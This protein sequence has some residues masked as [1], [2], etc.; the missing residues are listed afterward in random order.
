MLKLYKIIKLLDITLKTSNFTVARKLER[1]LTSKEYPA[2]PEVR[3]M[4]GLND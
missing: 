3:D 1:L 2:I 4:L